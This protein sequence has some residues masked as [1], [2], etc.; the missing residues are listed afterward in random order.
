MNRPRLSQGWACAVVFTI[1]S[2]FAA[3]VS[4]AQCPSNTCGDMVCDANTVNC[5]AGV[6][7]LIVD[8]TSDPDTTASSC[9]IERASKIDTC[10]GYGQTDP[11]DRCIEFEVYF[12]PDAVG[13]I[14][15]K[16]TPNP[17]GSL[18]YRLSCSSNTYLVGEVVCLPTNF[19]N[20][21]FI[22][23]CKPGNDASTYTIRSVEGFAQS[24]PE[25]TVSGCQATLSVSG[26]FH[27][28]SIVWTSTQDPAYDAFLSCNMGCATTTVTVPNDPN[29]PT[30]LEYQVCA[31]VSSACGGI[32]PPVCTT[33]QVL[34]LTPPIGTVPNYIECP[35]DFPVNA[36]ATPMDPFAA[37]QYIFYDGPN[38]TG[39]VV[40][41]QSATDNCDYATPGNKSVVIIDQSLV[42]FGNC[43]FDTANFTISE[44]P[45][46]N[47]D[48]TGPDFVCQNTGYTFSTPS[49]SGAS[50]SWD[51]GPNASPGSSSSR[52]VNNVTFNACG[53]Q[54]IMLT[55]TSSDGCDS[56]VWHV[57]QGDS[58][59]PDLSNCTLPNPVVDCG[60]TAQNNDN[61][62]AWH[63]S[64][65]ASLSD[66]AG[67][68]TDDCSWIVTHD[69]DLDNYVFDPNCGASNAGQITV[70]YTVYD[71]CQQST[72]S[73]T[74]TITDMTP[75][76]VSDPALNDTTYQCVGEIPPVE[77]NV[78]VIEDCG[79]ASVQWLG[80]T[81]SGSPCNLTI[82]RTYQITDACG[83]TTLVLQAFNINDVSDP[84]MTCGGQIDL[85]GCDVSALAGDP[86]VAML[87][88]STGQRPITMAEFNAL[89]GTVSDNC[90]IE[91]LYYTD[92]QNGSCPIVITRTFVAVDSCGNSATCDQIITVDDTVVPEVTCP[93]NINT[94]GCTVADIVT[95][96]GLAFS[97]VPVV[98]T[99]ATFEALDGLSDAYDSCGVRDVTYVDVLSADSCLYQVT[100]T[101]TVAD[102]CDNQIS[103]TQTII[104]QDVTD[105][106]ITCPQDISD[107][108]CAL[109]DVV[110]V[111]G[112]PFSSTV[113][114]ISTATYLGLPGNPGLADNCGVAYV[115][116]S[117]VVVP[118]GVCPSVE[119][120]QRTFVAYDSCLNSAT[121][122]QLISLEDNTAPSITSCP[123]NVI[124]NC[125]ESTDPSNTGTATAT[126]NCI[127]PIV[128]YTDVIV[129]G[130]C[131]NSYVIQ[132]TW[133][134]IDSCNITTCLQLITVQ[135]ITPPTISCP[136]PVD[137]EACNV[138]ALANEPLL[139][140]LEYS[141]AIRIISLADLVSQGGT[142]ADNCGID[143]LYYV[144]EMTSSCPTMITRTYVVVDS[145][146]LR[147]TC[148]QLITIDDTTL[149]S[150]TCPAQVDLEA[151]DIS[152]LATE[153]LLGN[154]AF[155]TTNQL[156]TVPIFQ[157][158][159]GSV[160]DNCGI[161]TIYYYDVQ[162]NSC[163]TEITR[164]FV[165]LD[166]CGNSIDCTQQITI[167]DTTPPALT[168]PAQVDLEACGV[169]VFQS[170]GALG[171]LEYSTS[172][173]FISVA[174]LQAA[175]GAVLDLCGI[176]SLYYRDQVTSTCPREITRTF[177]ATDSCNNRSSCTQLITVNDTTDPTITCP[178]QVDLEDCNVG[179]LAGESLVGN[180]AYS[181]S[182]RM[183]TLAE[184][185]G[186]GGTAAD[187]CGIDSLYYYDRQVNRC[188]IEVTRTFV[189]VD[190]CGNTVDCTQLITIDDTTIP[191]I[192]C[193]A[194]VDLEAC[195]VSVL[196]G[197]PSVGNLEYSTANRMLTLLEFQTAGGN[198]G[199]NC[200][201]D[202]LYYYDQQ[203]GFCPIEITRTFVV[204][205]SCG[206]TLDCTQLI[207]INDT[208]DP[209]LTC[210]AVVVLEG[211]DETILANEP[212]VGNLEYSPIIRFIT[213]AELAGAGGLVSDN[214]GFDS[215]YYSDLLAGSCP[216]LITRTFVAVDSCGNTVTCT[217]DITID[218]ITDPQL[219]CP[220]DL[221][222]EAC[223]VTALATEPLVGNLEFSTDIRF[224]T[225]PELVAAGGD[226]SDNC[227]I[228][229]LYYIDSQ[230]GLCPITVTRTFVVVDSCNNRVSC[231]QLITIDDTT[232]P[233][234]S[235]PAQVDLENCDVSALA[236][237]P[238]V[239]NLEYSESIRSITVGE[240]QGIGGA[241]LDL[242]GIDSLYYIDAQ[243]ST[244][245]IEVTRTFVATDSCGNRAECT[246][247]ITINDTT[248]PFITC[249]A[250]VD[251]EACNVGALATEPLV[252]DL[253][254]SP[255]VRIITLAELVAAG[256]T[257]G[258]NCGID[259]LYYF[260][261]DLNR[262]P[263]E[264]TRTFV[265]VDSCGN[266]VS[267]TQLITINDTTLPTI[268]C[269]GQVDLEAC[270]VGTLATEALVGNLA[271][272]LANRPLTLAEFVAAGG[273]AAD[274]C[275]FD[276][277]F[278]YDQQ[279]GFCPIEITR[280]F[281]VIDSCDNQASCTQLIT[282]N[283]TTDP[284]LLCP[285][286]VDLEGCGFGI[287]A[288]EP[289]VGNLE[290]STGIRDI[291]DA[292][293][294]AAGGSVSDNCGFDSLYYYDVAVGSC[295]IQITRTFVAVDSC[296]NSV[297][298]TQIITIDD[299]T[300][301]QL[302]CPVDVALEAC[303]VSTLATEQQ[304][305]NLEYS[306][307]I[308]FLS[309]AEMQAAGGDASDECAIDSLYYFDSQS[310]LCP[311][312][313]TR[314]FV[315]VDSCN[316][317]VSC[318]QLITIDDTTLPT[319]SCPAQLDLE[320]CDVSTLATEPLVGNLEYSETVRFIT[321][322]EL[323][324]I[325]GSAADPCGIDSLYYFDVQNETCPIEVTRTFVAT[326]SCGN[327]A[328]CTQLI[329]IND[330]TDPFLTCPSQVDLEDCNVGAL[331]SEP[332]VG[333][334]QF[335]PGIRMITLAELTAAGGTA[336]DNCGI[337]SLYYS[338]VAVNRCPIEI[339]RTF[340]VIDSCGNSF[341]CTQLITINDTTIPTITCPGQVDL[342]ACDVSVLASEP[343]VGNLAFSL[344]NRSITLAE[345]VAAGG[346]AADNCG[347][348]S[349][350]YFDVQTGFCP[351]E[352]TRTF[353]I[354]DSC[355]NQVSCTQLITI[356]DTTNPTLTCPG[357]VDLEG[358]GVGMLA[359][360]PSVGNL[361]YSTDIRILTPTELSVAG[362]S[363]SDNCGF[364]S[365][366]YY[367]VSIGSCPTEI[368]RTFVAVDSCGNSVECTQLITID[369]TEDPV[370]T[371]PV[372]VDLE[373]CD[374]AALATEPLV[375]NLAYSES[376]RIVTLAE[377]TA[378][379]GS[380]SDNCIIDSL[381]Y[382]DSQSGRCPIIVTR[383]FVVTDTCG[384]RVDCQQ[385]ITIDDTTLPVITCPNQVDLEACDLSALQTEALVG[386]LGY[387]PGITS[388]TPAQLQGTGATASDLCGIDSIYYRDLVTGACPMIITR[389][390]TVL[391]SCGNEAACDQI[392]TID[393]LTNPGITCPADLNL[394][395]C[396]LDDLATELLTGN[397]GYS[398]VPSLITLGEFQA[399]GGDASDGCGL[400]SIY[401][402]DVAV[403][404]CPITVTRT[405]AAVDSCGNRTECQQTITID[406]TTL[407]VLTCPAQVDLL[408]C[409]LGE[410]ALEPLVGNLEFSLINRPITVA[411]LQAS[412]GDASD[413][414]GIVDLYYF[415]NPSGD[416][417]ITI[418]RTFVL[419]D[420]CLNEVQCTQTITIDD[421]DGPQLTCPGQLDLEACDE[422]VLANEAAAGHLEYSEAVRFLT[423]AELQGAGGSAADNCGF[424]SLYYFDVMA[425][426][427][428]M[429]ITRTFVAVDS[430][431]NRTDCQQIININDLTA[432]VV[433]CP[434]DATYDGCSLSDVARLSGLAHSAITIII[435]QLT[436]EALE[437]GVSSIFDACGILSITYKDQVI[438]QRCPIVIER[439]FVV[440]DVCNQSSTC[441]QTITVQDVTLPEIDGVPGDETVDCD[442]VPSVPQLGSDVTATDNCGTPQLTFQ[443]DSIPGQCENTYSL[444]RTWTALD[445]C[446]NEVEATQT[447]TVVNC[448]PTVVI[449]VNPNPVCQ[450][451]TVTFTAVITDNY[452]APAYQWQKWDGSSWVHMPA[453]SVPFV[454][455]DVAVSDA[456]RYR[457]LVADDVANINDPDCRVTSNEVELVVN[458]VYNTVLDAE[459]CDGDTYNFHGDLL[460][461]SGTYVENLLS[462]AGCDSI[463]TLNLQ[464]LTILTESIAVSICENEFYDFGGEQLNMAGTYVDTLLSRLGCDSVVTL[465]LTIRP[466]VDSVIVASICEGDM[467]RFFGVAYR[468]AGVYD[469]VVTGSNGCDS[470]VILDLSVHPTYE[471]TL[472]EEIC[473]G[474][475]YVFH[476]DTL[477]ETGTYQ[478]ILTTVNG[479]DSTITLNLTVHPAYF[480]EQQVQ[481]CQD[482]S[483]EFYGQ[484][485]TETGIYTQ[486]FTTQSGCD[487]IIQLDLQVLDVL[488]T[489]LSDSICEGASYT[490]GTRTLN[491]TGTYVDSLVSASQ[492]DSIVTLELTVLPAL[493]T[494]LDVS[495]CDG[496][497]YPFN[498]SMLG[499]SGTYV[500][501]FISSFG[502]DSTVTLNLVVHP[503]YAISLSEQICA[504]DTYDF[505]GDVLDSTGTYIDSLTT[506]AGCDSV[507]TLNLVVHPIY[508][509]HVPI[510][511]CADQT[512]NFHGQTLDVAGTYTDTLLT[513]EGCDSVVVLD[514]EVLEILST[515]L[516]ESICEGDMYTFNGESLTTSGVY[517]HALV[518]ANGCD[519]VV[520]LNLT[521]HPNISVSL[522]A[523]ICQGETYAFNGQSL[524]AAGTYVETFTSAVG[525][526]S[527][528]TLDLVVHQPSAVSLTEQLCAGE[529]YDFNGRTL[530][531]TGVY[532]DSLVTGAGCDSVVTLSLTVYP[533]YD[534]TIRMQICDG[535]TFDFF[536]L[537]LGTAGTYAE[538]VPSAHGCDSTVTLLL[539]VLEILQTDLEEEIC[540]GE[541]FNFNGEILSQPGSYEQ[542]YTSVIG[543]DSVVTLD[544]TVHQ[545]QQTALT[546]EIC[547]GEVYA[548]A[549]DS[550]EVA[551]TYA[552]TLTSS[553]GCDSIVT[554]TLV[555]HR[556]AAT[557]LME[558][559]CQGEQF[560]FNGRS[561]DADGIYIDSLLTSE[562]CDSIVTLDLTVW[563][564]YDD[565]LTLQICEGDTYD[566][567]GNSLG[568]AGTYTE[569]VSTVHGCDSTVTLVL[570]VWETLRT[571]LHE[572]ICEGESFNFNGDVVS[573]TG[574]YSQSFASSIGCDSVV[575]LHLLVHSIP[576]TTL[577][578]EICQDEFYV[579]AG[580]TLNATGVYTETLTAITGCDSVVTLD[581]TVHP[582][583][584][585]PYDFSICEGENVQL[586]GKTY[587]Q[588]GTY[589][590]TLQTSQGCDSILIINLEVREIRYE[591]IEEVICDDISYDFHGTLLTVGGTYVDTL[592]S[593]L[594][595]DSVVTLELEVLEVQ[596]TQLDVQ[597]CLGQTYDF[598]GTIV[599][600]TG[601]YVDQ[602]TSENGCDSIV[603]LNFRAVETLE[604][605]I[606][607][608]ICEND[609]VI[610][611]GVA[612]HTAG[613]YT[614]SLIAAAGCDSVL[615][616]DIYVAPLE[617]TNLT[618]TICEGASL[619]FGS[620]T[621][622]ETGTYLDTLSSVFGCDSV[623]TLELTVVP[624][625]H[626]TL[627]ESICEGETYTVGMETFDVSG[628]Y[629]V[630]LIS[631]STGCDSVVTL[632]LTVI[633][634]AMSTTEVEICENEEY[635]FNGKVYHTSGTYIDTLIAASGC[636]SLSIL[637]LIVHPLEFSTEMHDLCT[638]EVAEIQGVQYGSDTTFVL[639]YPSVHGCDSSVTYQITVTPVV[640]LTG[641]DLAICEGESA[642]LTI[643]VEGT[644]D[645]V[646]LW[647]PAIGLS[648]TDCLSPEA[649]PDTTTTY[650]VSTVGCRGD[651]VEA[652]VTLT[653]EPYPGL[654]V[655][656]D[657]TIN[658]GQ[659]ITLMATNEFAHYP[660][661]WYDDITGELLCTD[662]PNLPR[663][664]SVPGEYR[665]RAESANNLGCAEEAVV[666][667]QAE[668]PC[669]LEKIVASNAF[670]PNGDGFNDYFEVRNDGISNITLVEVFSRWGEKV[671]E[672]S[673]SGDLWDG[674]F[675]GEPL[676]P[677]VFMYTIRGVCQ[678]DSDFI[679]TGNVTLIR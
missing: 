572:E 519:S 329:T 245:P 664:F 226:A 328:E 453:T 230:S 65:F 11:N 599:S 608:T 49:V 520:T 248:D 225:V 288:T 473:E 61:I 15:D 512:Y 497:T 492:C 418:L 463:V 89:G 543:C 522:D 416:C 40:C 196:A 270:D 564:T 31:D 207:T 259:S 114:R 52:V 161:D 223:D 119:S 677:A 335:S 211:C 584:E 419:V 195:D 188:P 432:P 632:D 81:P 579:F 605:F 633:P 56:T 242:C 98:I 184:F 173:R 74:Y 565:T 156:I 271:F 231:Q 555:V 64:N 481:L 479:C 27:E 107:D 493:Q 3:D 300:D 515:V 659:P 214:C 293:L 111:S 666:V 381:Y 665:Y 19:T 159:G 277:L 545:T 448:G 472:D 210:P 623:V 562:G 580:D 28:P 124:V 437:P 648:C 54:T 585:V 606:R 71:G 322:G 180:L 63:D 395:A 100:R 660:I 127:T 69:F 92:V 66:L 275:G 144:D 508:E 35:D 400:D 269:P 427:C 446:G 535:Y 325:G 541:T 528:V 243:T 94:E 586:A 252:A 459:M 561:L 267:C 612:Y 640:T 194:Q 47:A 643:S 380:A 667:L 592:T 160:S 379:G 454:I 462:A 477:T 324:G 628:N 417:P 43:A 106:T 298:C 668:D 58:L 350:F 169:S 76:V 138:G 10:C 39:A 239:G 469:E 377:L 228:D 133:E 150:I 424:D 116:Y 433:T 126:D 38:G 370:L 590:D 139:N 342:E 482:Q 423:L 55:V 80:D 53:D 443:Q 523:E 393:D 222:L 383:T 312:V 137:L 132:R 560:S 649:S 33:A 204:V 30:I 614:D 296:G 198:A 591:T 388:I 178:A 153:P 349:L 302:T 205:D 60:G 101:F 641:A 24:A 450:H 636:D 347:S 611:N 337:D 475:E 297:N 5:N 637:E 9:N 1:I 84:M 471:V 356:N 533:T 29:L 262:C 518:S 670:T 376:A 289:A 268:T 653:V 368:T 554:L 537:T 431:G 193:P 542:T 330:T 105:P 449:E 615:H 364:D 610:I 163:P 229:S 355:D 410:L 626:T 62:T 570:S 452:I 78:N 403:D 551:G 587:D 596:E 646:L 559:I 630:T 600:T 671:F 157:G 97:T 569:T 12:H 201:F 657:Q 16:T 320:A 187:N 372:Q 420:S 304:V 378:A 315:V 318:Q 123:P 158:L 241:A 478:E 402:F 6:P 362:G 253:P 258:D 310:G 103:C 517:E 280:T 167:D 26:V 638:G 549:G 583:Y 185:Q 456:G 224:L 639:V 669:E 247:L 77:T 221:A 14:L 202:S 428:P 7:H 387:S 287:L 344:A 361:E 305:G 291:T 218:D 571:D 235:C 411:E 303:D 45:L 95:V 340:V 524:T 501:T 675:R 647:E 70:E 209:S 93:A 88:F 597:V 348:D 468:I 589:F 282:I 189:V 382:F 634:L 389:T 34:I 176:D 91:E 391:D 212:T 42:S 236:T 488:S 499:T 672:S 547:E 343:L 620:R 257:A 44:Y 480:I 401:Y 216:I 21:I 299:T 203:T 576:Q 609:S 246:Q 306:E 430:C 182:I 679:L 413:N 190:S 489:H 578:A 662:C 505:N 75:P 170:T 567:F 385:I 407:P 68:V 96:S 678:D 652:F 256:G 120:I 506:S 607:D 495:I 286:Q 336:G 130:P 509:T 521:V 371:C 108:G 129:P 588:S 197:E 307:A 359:T 507:V 215:L 582:R 232:L 654:T 374:V 676:N 455:D 238:L 594:G 164:T 534:D 113:A 369:D 629:E 421:I 593:S 220:T 490:F 365:L 353:V 25:V 319:I 23:F 627:V 115:E 346:T 440:T 544:L 621:L 72:I 470:V 656:P 556:P 272:S 73:A 464:V 548:F 476:G 4:N 179:T 175:G 219:T 451:E 447:I 491:S 503:T 41:P 613:T 57:A 135:D 292:E 192:S 358:C 502:C 249:P 498:G 445:A 227:V 602:F 104:I 510:Q 254:Y 441:T 467:Y 511:I 18:E 183:L 460:T 152:A 399:A 635:T 655:S 86:L 354:V 384:N 250:Q 406:D 285:G 99:E 313:V 261:T 149:P 483:H 87:E 625:L 466:I 146:D 486:S 125:D 415:D 273:T 573:E 595:C 338:D 136:G 673:V 217:Q 295:P 598:N 546:A 397:L 575:T 663:N 331:S 255:G 321:V 332:L 67:C 326:D 265:V 140:N 294:V 457:L 301:P 323:Q 619:A 316:N 308:R 327:R 200:G 434:T 281:V 658:L 373:A 112:L 110:T 412:G 474:S 208:T 121:C 624:T 206:N 566:F 85:E 651:V 642:T 494:A 425:G 351:I 234:I 601:T 644:E 22:T 142:A 251:L 339:T 82:V 525:C 661:N 8:L 465:D 563:P 527:V 461:E 500:E 166:S 177:V 487:S 429:V 458:P 171:N 513:A 148:T 557:T 334:L 118:P 357:P 186:A 174:E 36:T 496:E 604:V 50:Y 436:F 162:V 408:L 631:T 444:V 438:N 526:D 414:C 352:I 17:P 244:C 32:F 260:D 79:S 650:R 290:Y 168:C 48:I 20:P 283:D 276:S 577:N 51:F 531:S 581:L 439:T 278:Y 151:C 122:T 484:T 109:P 311:M 46:P 155:S 645:P 128:D 266:A 341:S 386:N 143:S 442:E 191:T 392:I 530:D 536:D 485:L 147:T 131:P 279:T 333:N 102:D 538:T 394:E 317:R 553:A 274:N 539:E 516:D 398:A 409:G 367:D 529:T 674:T 2:L 552:E 90:G 435:D 181:E 199:D 263:I 568:T 237:E 165:A 309:V 514:L 134:I 37:Y 422:G 117:D 504:G 532:V 314:T 426:S 172:I 617:F 83:N 603:T 550:L 405:F 574:T 540:E 360:E 264:V 363:V 622:T 396:G 375:G 616:I 145:C 390:F 618:E 154:L 345:L 13:L 213:D 141:E 233:T 558:E 59:P 284:T 240:L 404:E 366:Y